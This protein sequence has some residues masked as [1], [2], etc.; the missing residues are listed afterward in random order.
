MYQI[1]IDDILKFNSLEFVPLEL[2]FKVKEQYLNNP[3]IPQDEKEILYEHVDNLILERNNLKC[4][5]F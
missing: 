1:T 3:D 2:L 4:T 5:K